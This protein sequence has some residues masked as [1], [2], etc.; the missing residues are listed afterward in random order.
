MI[1]LG[2]FV[3]M[4]SVVLMV[5]CHAGCRWWTWI[6]ESASEMTSTWC[7]NDGY[8]RHDMVQEV[9]KSFY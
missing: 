4:V 1:E 9:Q 8:A 3:S 5:P 6:P 7:E 2:P